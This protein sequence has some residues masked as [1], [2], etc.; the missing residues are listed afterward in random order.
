MREQ[1]PLS[2]ASAEAGERE[3]RSE[4]GGIEQAE[5]TLRETLTNY[6][7]FFSIPAAELP[8]LIAQAESYL[9]Q[10]ETDQDPKVSRRAQDILSLPEAQGVTAGRQ[11]ASP[12]P[13]LGR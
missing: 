10:D 8:E 6:P 2:R 4:L 1:N 9:A 3:W 7:N 12:Q 13:R 11:N 5:S